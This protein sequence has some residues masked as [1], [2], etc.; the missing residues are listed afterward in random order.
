MIELARKFNLQTVAEWVETP[1]D[2]ELLTQW[3]VDYLQGNLF[4]EA[5]V[6]PPW[7][8]APASAGTAVSIVTQEAPAPDLLQVE[9]A[10]EPVLAELEPAPHPAEAAEID[11]DVSIDYDLSRLRAAIAALDSGFNGKKNDEAAEPSYADLVAPM[12]Q[13]S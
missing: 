8:A 5:S 6:I 3:N 10:P 9:A 11:V 13:A 7:D 4:G 12:R 2:A 1:E